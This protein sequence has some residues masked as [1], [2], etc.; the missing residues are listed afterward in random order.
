MHKVLFPLAILVAG[1]AAA[2]TATAAPAPP[3]G[4]LSPPP[5]E[6]KAG[7]GPWSGRRP[8]GLFSQLDLTPTQRASIRQFRRESLEQIRPEVLA[9]QR[10]EAA[11]NDAVPGTPEYRA[12]ANDLAHAE[13][14]VALVRALHMSDLRSRIYHILTPTQKAQLATLRAQ[15]RAQRAWQRT[16]RQPAAA[17]SVAR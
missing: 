15:R 2:A 14:D 10:K 7:A 9:L 1:L 8:L 16:H 13:A 5:K 17:S 3:D 4:T 6:A 11:F 12:A